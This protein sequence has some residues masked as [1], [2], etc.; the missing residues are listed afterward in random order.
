ME[1]T[2]FSGYCLASE[3][4]DRAE[5]EALSLPP[6]PDDNLISESD[7]PPFAYEDDMDD[8]GIALDRYIRGFDY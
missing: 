7:L 1:C 5:L 4:A 3:A 6:E 2:C 8:I